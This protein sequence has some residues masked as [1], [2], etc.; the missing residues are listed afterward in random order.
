MKNLTQL[1]LGFTVI[2]AC[3]TP[4]LGGDTLSPAL[5]AKAKELKEADNKYQQ[6]ACGT[7][8]K[9]QLKG[10]HDYMLG[11][12]Q[13][14]IVAD[15][16]AGPRV[17]K[18]LD[19]AT[20]AGAIA[21]KTAAAPTAANEE[22]AFTAA[23]FQ[24]AK[25]ELHAVAAREKAFLESEVTKTYG[26]A[27]AAAEPCVAKAPPAEREHKQAKARAARR[28]HQA[29]KSGPAQSPQPFQPS[30]NIGGGSTSFSLSGSSGSITFGR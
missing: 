24:Q 26:V 22:K 13:K 16:S 25:T 30:V 19:D 14:L 17:Q 2:A 4:A 1:C 18:A 6:A 9:D 15:V 23:R 21:D 10:M 28:S 7:A 3:A 29:A 27:L 11:E 20:A 8:L 5:A 12:V